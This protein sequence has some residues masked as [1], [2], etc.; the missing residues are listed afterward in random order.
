MGKVDEVKE[1]LNT[2]R[3][4]LSLTIGMIV[5]TGGGLIKRYDSGREDW[6]FWSGSLLLL[7]LLLALF[8]II[9]KISQKTKEIKD[10]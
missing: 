10:I 1:I 5:V 2:L 9:R 6:I 7:L 8:M 4:W 3:V